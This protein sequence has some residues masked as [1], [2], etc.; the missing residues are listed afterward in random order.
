MGQ[1]VIMKKPEE[2]RE[3]PFTVFGFSKRN[4]YSLSMAGDD[5]VLTRLVQKSKVATEHRIQHTGYAIN[6]VHN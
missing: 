3:I 1:Q 6:L 4:D 2:G 5:I